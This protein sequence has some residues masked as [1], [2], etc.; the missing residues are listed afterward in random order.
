MFNRDA[1]DAGGVK[2]FF[3]W[4]LTDRLCREKVESSLDD[5]CWYRVS[6]VEIFKIQYVKFPYQRARFSLRPANGKV[7]RIALTINL[8]AWVCDRKVS[9]EW[10]GE[11]EV[12]SSPS[13]VKKNLFKTR[14][15]SYL[16]NYGVFQ[17]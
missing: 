8:Y 17:E 6:L 13:K 16:T 4:C 9:K 2:K 11:S 7:P 12:N 14:K 5:S 15:S 3:L 10:L 1:S